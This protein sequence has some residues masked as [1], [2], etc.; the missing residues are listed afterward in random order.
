MGSK[1]VK[2]KVFSS[3]EDGKLEDRS[4]KD[5]IGLSFEIKGKYPEGPRYLRDK[6][7]KVIDSYLRDL[8][9]KIMKLVKNWE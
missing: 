5:C 8:T 3:L 9:F 1:I 4:G 2:F 7:E 6:C